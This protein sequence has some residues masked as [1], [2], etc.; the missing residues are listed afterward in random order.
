VRPKQHNTLNLFLLGYILIDYLHEDDEMV[1]CRGSISMRMAILRETESAAFEV[2]S[3]PSRPHDQIQ[4]WFMKT[5][6]SME[7]RRWTQAIAFAKSID[8][9]REGT[10]SDAFPHHRSTSDLPNP[11]AMSSP[12]IFTGNN[13]LD[14]WVNKL[15]DH[16]SRNDFKEEEK[17]PKAMEYLSVDVRSAIMKVQSV[18]QHVIAHEKGPGGR[19]WILSYSRL[20]GALRG[21]QSEVFSIIHSRGTNL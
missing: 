2:H 21:M 1:A 14:S 19:G 6:D 8:K 9:M 4:K 15:N 16:F 11:L 20:V 13:D 5:N 18:L 3:I 10:D 17:L 12:F 7:A